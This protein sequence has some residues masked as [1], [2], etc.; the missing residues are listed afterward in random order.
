MDRLASAPDVWRH[1]YDLTHELG[2]K[3]GTLYPILMR[4]A[5]QGLLES[6]WE[7]DAPPGRP[8]RHLYRLSQAGVEATT[9]ER[10]SWRLSRAATTAPGVAGA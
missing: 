9:T 7:T 8:P 1:G 2:V 10:S 4:L 5:D 6:M 3:S